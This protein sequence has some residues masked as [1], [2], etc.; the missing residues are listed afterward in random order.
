MSAAII[1]DEVYKKFGKPKNWLNQISF[2]HLVKKNGHSSPAKS[3]GSLK[4]EQKPV[5]VAVD[6]VSF[7]VDTGEIFGVLGPNGSGKSTLIRLIA[8]LLLPDRGSIQV[9]GYDVLRQPREVQRLINRVSV[10]ASFFKKLSPMENLIYGARLYGMSGADI[11][12]QVVEI[13]TR[14]GLEKHSIYKP[15]EEMSRG[16]QQKVA[17][18]RALLSQP[19]VLL[20]DEPTTGLDP[21]SKREVQAVIRELNQE[22]GT[23]ILLTTHD[24]LEA[25]TLC[26]RVAIIDGGKIVALDTPQA[27]KGVIS[28][29]GHEPTLEDVFLELTGKQLVKE[30][31]ME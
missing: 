13:L 15:M 16:M 6:Q 24:M 14:L 18:A 9:F 7:T 20:L 25:D 21:R 17:I 11:R 4:E 2:T 23:T 28:S 8:T 12:R 29:N 1:V 30:S 3:N 26:S 5:V 22:H 31:E 10:E 27:L 19:K